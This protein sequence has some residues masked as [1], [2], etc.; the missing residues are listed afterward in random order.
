[1]NVGQAKASPGAQCGL[2]PV[3]EVF[4]WPQPRPF[5]DFV[6]H[7]TA[8]STVWVGACGFCFVVSC[9]I[10]PLGLS[11][12]NPLISSLKSLFPLLVFKPNL[13]R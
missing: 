9:F 1:M 5:E 8:V 2:N 10:Y 3:S 6:A 12:S 11:R 7:L 13:K 4:F